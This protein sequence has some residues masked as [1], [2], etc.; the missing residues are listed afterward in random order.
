MLG[1]RSVCRRFIGGTLGSPFG[2]GEECTATRTDAVMQF[3]QSPHPPGKMERPFRILSWGGEA[4]SLYFYASQS[5][6]PWEGVM[7]GSL[8]WG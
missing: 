8:W 4:E 6:L 2:E 7:S 3:Q 5:W 1:W